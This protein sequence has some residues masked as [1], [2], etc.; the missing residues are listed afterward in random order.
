[1][2]AS[3]S[4]P[5]LSGP[6]SAPAVRARRRDR[7][8]FAK[9]YARPVP[10]ALALAALLASARGEDI[11]PKAVSRSAAL[12][13][14]LSAHGLTCEE[15]DIAWVT[16]ANGIEGAMLGGARALVRAHVA[17]EPNDLYLV[18]ARLSPEGVLL[19]VGSLWN[20]TH[21]MG[22]DESRPVLARLG[23]RTFAATST[24]LDG[25]VKDVHVFDLAGQSPAQY[26]EFTRLQR[27]QLALGNLQQTGQTSGVLHQVF[28]LDPPAGQI[29]LSF[30]P[31]GKLTAVADKRRI[32]IDAPRGAT[33]EGAGWVRTR[34]DVKAA[35]GR[36]VTWAVDRVRALPWFGEEKMQVV[37]AVAFT[38][39]DWAMRVRARIS[40]DATEQEVE[41]DLAGINQG[42]HQPVFTDP[43]LGW[44]PTAM[45]PI[46]TP[47]LPGEGQWI[48]L[49]RDP[50]IRQ[51]P[52]LPSPFVTSFVRADK[53]R[54]ETRVYVTLWDPRQIALHMQAGTVEPVSATGEAG[55][56]EVPRTPEVWNHLVAG[57]NGGFQAMH[58]EYGMQADGALYLPPKPYAATVLEM[59]DG[60]TAF[61]AWPP[62]TPDVG[63]EVLS[64][65]QNLTA[66]VQDDRFNPWGRTW[67]GG[68]PKGWADEV[69][70]TRSGLC[71]TKENFVGYFWGNDISADVLANAMLAA[72]CAFGMHLDMN[73]GHAGFEFYN[74]QPKDALT[75]LG[76]PL[77]QDWEF[78]GSLKSMPDFRVRARRMVKGMGHM[79]FPRY[80][81]R[82]ERDFFYLTRRP[83]LPGPDVASAITPAVPGEGTWRVKGLP[84]H[85]F[86]YAMAAT[87]V[88][89]L[90]SRP[91]V[92]VRVLRIDPRTVR[93]AASAG[94]TEQTP[95]V[96]SFSGAHPSRGGPGQIG[97]WL[98]Q[99]LFQALP[100]A[101]SEGMLLAGGES[102]AASKGARTFAG[103]DDE[104]GMLVW[105][106]LDPARSPDAETTAAIDALLA[107][108][109]C[110]TRLAT[111]GDAHAFPGGHL[112]IAG[113]PVAEMAATARLVRGETAG[114]H[115][116]FA[117]TPIVR[118]SVWQP[119]QMQRVRYFNKR[120]PRSPSSQASAVPLL[121][122]GAPR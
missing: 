33:V 43:E 113:E 8:G 87:W 62:D 11:D 93:A 27:W 104:E 34:P 9:A 65:R 3:L 50:F 2:V 41:R 116:Q 40:P 59:K 55:T 73:T 110:S 44:P 80:I 36:L 57:F 1:M 75:A 22:V 103:I 20:L 15:P 23:G 92:K 68:T 105:I 81:H 109:G 29:D 16:G 17:K 21:S 48:S 56:G 14:V 84:Q 25:V 120:A 51:G 47:P 12:I 77:Q 37:K 82:D 67:W 13:S 101:P 70:T 54:H 115:P 85:G 91:D 76:R 107:R 35:P 4:K 45:K 63:D 108:L 96:V 121:D 64:F 112:D 106:E 6:D 78:E 31:D 5:P 98:S 117:S 71:L 61:G 97:I 83:L 99:G 46:V 114:A 53:T 39:L 89:P 10:Y 30:A 69:H 42:Q 66:L 24:S 72:R 118:P 88:R 119:L 26:T 38:A 19:D 49:E 28:E 18:E 122:A 74:A 79:N 90:A 95:T 58:G 86:P 52:G 100:N 111:A 102:I 60:S 94:T 7:I 32:V